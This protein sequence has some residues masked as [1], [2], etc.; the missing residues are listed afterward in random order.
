MRLLEGGRRL[1]IMSLVSQFLRSIYYFRYHIA[2]SNLTLSARSQCAELCHQKSMQPRQQAGSEDRLEAERFN[3]LVELAVTLWQAR[4]LIALCVVVG[5]SLGLTSAL[6]TAKYESEGFYQFGGPIPIIDQER[7]NKD[8]KKEKRRDDRRDEN[9]KELAPGIALADFKRLSAS[10]GTV[11]RFNDYISESKQENEK[12]V[13]ALRRQLITGG[14]SGIIEP[15]Y[16]Y[17]KLDAK[18]LVEQPK[19]SSNNV[20]GLRVKYSAESKEDARQMVA[21]LGRYAMDTIVYGVYSD[22]IMFKTD[23]IRAKLLAIDSTILEQKMRLEKHRRAASRFAKIAAEYPLAGNQGVR[24]VVEITEETARFLPP[25]TLLTTARVEEADAIEAI[26]QAQMERRQNEVLLAYYERVKSVLSGTKSGEV[27]LRR[28]EEI[29]SDIFGNMDLKD[30]V[31]KSVY[32]RISVDNQ[33]AIN[34][35]LNKS[36]FIAGPT[37]PQKSTARPAMSLFIGL[38]LGFVAAVILALA[39]KWWNANRAILPA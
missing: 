28:L 20:I 11:E 17:T 2:P 13:D 19:G 36:R 12:G 22:A 26:N 30:E 1:T 15:V 7:S 5:A 10:Y 27:V 25:T 34:V 24:Q 8:R 29:K 14:V 18:I 35:Y 21:L 33:N 4:W 16:P 37:F 9:E 38:I 31:V 23:E 32:N 6:F 3:S 39:Q